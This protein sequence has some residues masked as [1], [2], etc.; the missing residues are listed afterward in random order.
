[1]GEKER[2]R[3]NEGVGDRGYLRGNVQRKTE[4]EG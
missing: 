1:M 2:K 4:T 3:E